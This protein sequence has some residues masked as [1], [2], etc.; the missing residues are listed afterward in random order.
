MIETW[1]K[2]LDEHKIVGATL[3]DLS[4]AFN[5]LPHYLLVAKPGGRGGTCYL[6]VPGD[7]PFSCVYFLP[8]NSKAGYNFCPKI[9]NWDINFEEK[10]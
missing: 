4:K 2:C 8:K 1:G 7:V 3:T 10:F 5:C 6:G 9:L